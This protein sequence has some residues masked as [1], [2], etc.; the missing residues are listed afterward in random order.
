MAVGTAISRVTGVLRI[1]A[2]AYALG[3]TS[4]SDAYNL[5]N[6]MPNIV[7]DLVIGVVLAATFVPVFM[8]RLVQRSEEEAWEAISA[9]VSVALVLLAVTSI[10]FLAAAPFIVDLTTALV[11]GTQARLQRSVATELLRLFVPQLA[12]YGFISIATA[13][14]NATRRFAAPAFAPIANN[15]VLITLLVS[16]GT[17]V[18]HPTL[19]SIQAHQGELLVLGMGTTIG[20]VVQGLLLVPSLRRAGI[21]LRWHL[22][23]RHEAVLTVLRLSGWTLGFVAANQA[24][25]V[26]VLALSERAGPGALTSYTYAYT[27]FQL[28]FG[29]IAISVMATVTPELARHWATRDLDAFRYRLRGGL[30]AVMAVVL[31]AAAGEVVL[32]R[33][34]VA[35]LFGHGA[36]SFA[37][38]AQSAGA[39]GML[40][41]GLPGFCAFLYAIRVLQAVQDTR[42]AFWL[43]ALENGLNVAGALLLAG[44]LGLRGIALS[45]SVAY[46][47]A[48]VAAFVHLSRRFDHL[49]MAQEI[50]SVRRVVLST[51][52]LIAGAALASNA[53]SSNSSFGVAARVVLGAAGGGAAYLAVAGAGAAWALRTSGGQG[54]R[55]PPRA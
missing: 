4:L 37:T 52:A 45:I 19:A 16:F 50:R 10:V 54:T 47:L 39:L 29:V 8:E 46:S 17:V 26:V 49:G 40:A 35:M 28:P 41:I 48:A 11:H 23:P 30:R 1:F 43:Y 31:P 33:P 3:F 24:A 7:H 53:L 25:L 9:V 5:A 21:Q 14:L 20:V 32:A 38:T 42:S 44:P 13:L 27:V 2:L 12:A 18:K 34:L 36:G 55:P 15:L 22:A 6:T 51:I